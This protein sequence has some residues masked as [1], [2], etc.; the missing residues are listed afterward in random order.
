ME[1]IDST[2]LAEATGERI[3]RPAAARVYKN[4]VHASIAGDRK[5]S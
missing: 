1:I 4:N 2:T 3:F 5:L